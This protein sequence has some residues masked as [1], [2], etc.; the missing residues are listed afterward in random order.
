VAGQLH[1][2]VGVEV[3]ISRIEAKVKMSQNRPAADLDG[4]VAGLEAR[5]RRAHV[6]RRAL[7]PPDLI[8][9]EARPQWYTASWKTI[10]ARSTP[11]TAPSP[12]SALGMSR[13]PV[14]EALVELEREGLIVLR[15]YRGAP[16]ITL[17]SEDARGGVGDPRHRRRRRLDAPLEG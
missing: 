14:R 9:P 4:V 11:L 3:V 10:S 8:P 17:T 16:V 12:A 6:R 2:I 1:A 15:R 13:G 7:R 5:G